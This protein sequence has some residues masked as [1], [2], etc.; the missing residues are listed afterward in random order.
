MTMLKVTEL[1]S[2]TIVS[3]RRLHGC[4][5]DFTQ[6]TAKYVAKYTQYQDAFV[7]FGDYYLK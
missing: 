3:L 5:L 4:V 1:F 7:K 2:T 6:L